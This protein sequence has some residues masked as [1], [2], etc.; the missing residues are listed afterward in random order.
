ML[1]V[2]ATLFAPTVVTLLSQLQQNF[3]S[4][5]LQACQP[6]LGA[7]KGNR[8]DRL[9]CHYVA[10]VGQPGDRVQPAWVYEREVLPH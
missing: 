9:E 5:G 10:H 8:A 6:D 7:R 2:P 4:A 3:K 1:F